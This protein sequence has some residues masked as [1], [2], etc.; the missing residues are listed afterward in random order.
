MCVN[1]NVTDIGKVVFMDNPSRT[2]IAS[3]VMGILAA[4]VLGA[5]LALFG[6]TRLRK[7]KQ[8]E[9]SLGWCCCGSVQQ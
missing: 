3:I 5:T 2:I 1:G 8:G 6:M 4:V 9:E 7:T